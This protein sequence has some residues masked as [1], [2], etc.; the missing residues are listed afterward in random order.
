[1][2]QE[3]D[4]SGAQPEADGRDEFTHRT[5]KADGFNPEMEERQ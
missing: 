5:E 4:E 2:A 1:M 3:N